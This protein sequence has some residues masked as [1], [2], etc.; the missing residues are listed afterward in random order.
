MVSLAP[1]PRANGY[2][3]SGCLPRRQTSERAYWAGVQRRQP[4]PLDRGY[5]PRQMIPVK[6]VMTRNVITFSEDPP[7]D[8]LAKTLLSMHIT[9]A[10]VVSGESHLVWIFAVTNGLS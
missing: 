5:T 3:A 10:P 8:E 2:A 7:V 9:G 1:C 6:E 4:R